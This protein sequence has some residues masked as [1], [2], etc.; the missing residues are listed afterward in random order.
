MVVM[1]LGLEYIKESFFNLKEKSEKDQNNEL[2]SSIISTKNELVYAN[3]NYEFAQDDLIDYFLYEIKAKEAKLNFLVKEAKKR[4]IELDIIE[5]I[6][7]KQDKV[8]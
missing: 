8:V 7:F 5:A 3:Q 2:I 1:K 4:N 6:Q